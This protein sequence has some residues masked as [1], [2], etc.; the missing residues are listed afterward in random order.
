MPYKRRNYKK[1]SYRPTYRSCGTMVLSDAKRALI[2]VNKLKNLLNVEYKHHNLSTTATAIT[3]AG[4]VTQLSNLAQ[5]DT[6][7]T[8]DGGSVKWTSLQ[9]T[10]QMKIH[11]SATTSMVR[12]MIVHDKQPN[13]A[14]FTLADLLF[15]ATIVDACT[16]PY[17]INN[18]S[19][20]NIIY[21]K[22]HALNVNS[23][24]STVIRKIHKKLNLKMRYD[25]AVGDITDQTQD[26]L[27]LVL[28]AD[29]ATNDP[30]IAFSYRGRFIDN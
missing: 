6:S 20:F 26:S 29:Q 14:I 21:D 17:N 3:D 27:A 13:Q 24:N 10:Y 8:R 7:T 5:G 15:D 9:L 12:I 22:L 4:S 23:S 11:V 1:R 25:A 2:K 28:V 19:R 18:A 30:V 16:S